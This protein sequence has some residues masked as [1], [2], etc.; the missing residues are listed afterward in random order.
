MNTV[1]TVTERNYPRLEA[2]TAFFSRAREE[3]ERYRIALVALTESVPEHLRPELHG[4]LFEAK[5]SASNLR[6]LEELLY[7]REIQKHG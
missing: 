4:R 5:T 6:A 3:L 1:D 2:Y 7:Y